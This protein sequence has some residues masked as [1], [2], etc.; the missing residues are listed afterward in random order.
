MSIINR[1]IFF[2]VWTNGHRFRLNAGYYDA[3]FD[4]IEGHPTLTVRATDLETGESL[5]RKQFIVADDEKMADD[6][7]I[8]YRAAMREFISERYPRIR[9]LDPIKEQAV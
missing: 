2:G 9:L 3:I 4:P 1:A 5:I 7:V 8:T 6:D